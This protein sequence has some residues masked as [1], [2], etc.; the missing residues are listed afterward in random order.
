MENAFNFVCSG[1]KLIYV[2]LFI[3]DVQFHDPLFHKNE[4]T[5][6]A[7]RNALPYEFQKIISLMEQNKID[8]NQW[9]THSSNFKEFPNTIE[10]W[11][12][13]DQMVIKGMISV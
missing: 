6:M 8:I 2:G 12:D 11:I 1:G 5:L 10:K 3:G 7:T 13:P 9:I 4:I